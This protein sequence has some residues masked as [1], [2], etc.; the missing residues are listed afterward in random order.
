VT[1]PE[2]LKVNIIEPFE[3]GWSVVM[4]WVISSCAFANDEKYDKTDN[5][6]KAKTKHFEFCLY[7]I[8]ASN[9]KKVKFDAKNSCNSCCNS[10][11]WCS[12]YKREFE[13]FHNKTDIKTITFLMV[14]MTQLISIK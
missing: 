8:I 2:K 11:W 13:K 9:W 12:N 10:C 6:I 3:F 1:S 14:L 4:F 7:E 5:K